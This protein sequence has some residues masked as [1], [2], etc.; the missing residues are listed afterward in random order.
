VKASLLRGLG[1]SPIGQWRFRVPLG[2]LVLIARKPAPAGE[3]RP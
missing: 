1:T 2:N 3:P